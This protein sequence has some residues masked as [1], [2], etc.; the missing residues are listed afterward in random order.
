MVVVRL[1]TLLQLHLLEQKPDG[2][3]VCD[4]VSQ[5]VN[6]AVVLLQPP[7]E[8]IQLPLV[9][10]RPLFLALLSEPMQPRWTR[11]LTCPSLSDPAL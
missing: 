8:L 9:L 1:L 11:K 2:R 10:S 6:R 3:Q 7:L 5:L 4:Y